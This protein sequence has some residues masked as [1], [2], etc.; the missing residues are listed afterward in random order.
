MD[1][2]QP[3]NVY[4]ID[5]KTHK[6]TR[7]TL[8]DKAGLMALQAAMK[9]D[10][11]RFAQIPRPDAATNHQEMETFIA[12]VHDPKLKEAMKRCLT[13]HKPFREFRDLLE[14]KPKEK[15]EW[16]AFHR[17]WSEQKVERF[18]KASSLA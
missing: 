6:V 10:P 15:R 13:S 5:R 17:K 8:E 7:Y 3:G 14:T 18:L 1:D 4:F 16:E 2:L 9:T 11:K 12:S